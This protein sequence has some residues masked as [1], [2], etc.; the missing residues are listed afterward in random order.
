MSAPRIYVPPRRR[1]QLPIGPYDLERKAAMILALL[2]AF[3]AVG[4]IL[5]ALWAHRPL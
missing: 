4:V 2:I 1:R 3:L 5:W